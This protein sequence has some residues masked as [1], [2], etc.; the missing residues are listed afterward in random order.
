MAGSA[1]VTT[2][3]RAPHAAFV[4]GFGVTR[5]RSARGRS[6]PFVRW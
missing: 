1:D 3:T 4:L 2:D 6:A 5:S